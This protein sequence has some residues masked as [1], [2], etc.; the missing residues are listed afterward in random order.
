[1]NR[2]G[3]AAGISRGS[4]AGISRAALALVVAVVAAALVL[5][6][7]AMRSGLV[8]SLSPGPGSS[9]ADATGGVASL[10]PV[11]TVAPTIGFT[12]EP[13]EPTAIPALDGEYVGALGRSDVCPLLVQP[14]GVLELILPD[15]YRGRVRR[16]RLQIV[17]PGGTVLANE[18]DLLGLD[19]RVRNGGSFCMVG[20]QLHVSRIVEVVRRGSS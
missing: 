8:P 12:P 14:D 10:P 19:G 18:G 17:G 2:D 1:M 15:G 3:A 20:P 13:P 11:P 6:S 4:A 9:G 16:D 5:T 7:G